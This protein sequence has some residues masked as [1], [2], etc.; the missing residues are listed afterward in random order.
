MKKLMFAA[1]VAAMGV[2]TFADPEG[3][4]YDVALTI[5]TTNAKAAKN[6]SNKNNPIAVKDADKYDI[7][8]RAQTSVSWKGLIWG[9]DCESID[10]VWENV[11]VCDTGDTAKTIKGCVIWDVKGK[12]VVYMGNG[13]DVASLESIADTVPGKGF[14]WWMLQCIGKDGKSL[15]TT[16]DLYGYAASCEDVFD[17]QI[18]F[19]FYFAGF[20]KA[21]LKTEKDDD[22][23][24]LV[25]CSSS[26]NS[27]SGNFAGYM[28][29]PSTGAS[30]KWGCSFCG[31]G[32]ASWCEYA[33]AWAWCEDFDDVC[34]C[35]VDL[36]YPSYTA[37]YGTWSVKYNSSLSKKLSK[38]YSIRDAYNFK[39][40][41]KVAEAIAVAE[42]ASDAFQIDYA[43]AVQNLKDAEA[44]L[45][46]AQKAQVT[47][48]ANNVV[49]AAEL[50]DVEKAVNLIKNVWANRD[51]NDENAPHVD[52]VVPGSKAAVRAAYEATFTALTG[53]PCTDELVFNNNA[54]KAKWGYYVAKNWV[55]GSEYTNA[56]ETADAAAAAKQTADGNVAKAESALA[57]AKYE[58]EAA[59]EACLEAGE[60]CE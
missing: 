43:V 27:L 11:E 8:Y 38:V 6:I 53:E 57:T 7:T 13:A 3:Q 50:A 48:A 4:V 26:V 36:F 24:S 17:G 30:A 33:E 54:F 5:K 52:P 59:E 12:A 19:D 16:G 45:E 60:I 32:S 35:N 10:G 28:I 20:G 22:G 1:A 56:K 46:T 49:A 9:C 55:D 18:A 2:T 42:K 37:A 44:A 58:L 40:L 47:A 15:E 14:G 23:L 39:S 31:G 25:L 34:D 29:A 51:A 41:P 21:T